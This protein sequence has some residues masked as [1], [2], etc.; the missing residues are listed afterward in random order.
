[1]NDPHV[2]SLTYEVK[3]GVTTNFS[4]S[5]SLQ[6]S[7]DQF[8]LEVREGRAVF[9]FKGHLSTEE[10]ARAVV[11][12]FIRAWEVWDGTCTAPG[13]LS[14]VFDKSMIEDRAPS[15]KGYTIYPKSV[16]F[17]STMGTP[18]VRWTRDYPAPPVGFVASPD[19]QAMYYQYKGLR[20]GEMS[21]ATVA[22][23]CLNLLEDRAG[24]RNLAAPMYVIDKKVLRMMGHL[25]SE[26]GG[27]DARK[28]EGLAR[29]YSG[30]EKQW[31]EAAIPLLIR[32]VGEVEAGQGKPLA[33][34]TMADLPNL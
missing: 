31:L 5:A 19:V 34:I 6:T 13:E 33:M 26:K 3:S 25:S 7:N 9:S 30:T 20:Q 12:P 29:P 15:G 28:A 2:V 11:E 27:N 8:D 21:L 18:T 1:M 17:T 10:E 4:P 16:A 24:S 22:Y 14:F 23:L 32:R